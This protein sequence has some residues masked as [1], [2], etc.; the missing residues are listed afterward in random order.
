MPR[1]PSHIVKERYNKLKPLMYVGRA[2]SDSVQIPCI[3]DCGKKHTVLFRYLHYKLS[4]SC[5]CI[6]A[7]ILREYNEDRYVRV[8]CVT[9]GKKYQSI[10]QAAIDNNISQSGL[11]KALKKFG[12]IK[13]L[14]FRVISQDEHLADKIKNCT[15]RS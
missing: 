5:G 1:Q 15:N 13:N 14:Q 9:T 12:R 4:Q 6:L 7:D 10:K 3:C 8:L 2:L 11:N